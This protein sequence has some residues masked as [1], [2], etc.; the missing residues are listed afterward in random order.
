MTIRILGGIIQASA[1]ALAITP[2]ANLLSYPLSTILGN[3]IL[4]KTEAL[5]IVEPEHAPKAAH[6]KHVAIASPPRSL[7][8]QTFAALKISSVIPAK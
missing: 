1:P 7:P 3:V 4:V 5:A 2:E 6:A 8:N